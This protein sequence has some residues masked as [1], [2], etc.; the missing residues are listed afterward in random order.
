MAGQKVRVEYLGDITT[1]IVP[2]MVE[3]GIAVQEP[4]IR[5]ALADVIQETHGEDK[6]RSGG[7]LSALTSSHTFFKRKN[8]YFKANTYFKRT[9]T[10]NDTVVHQ[11]NKAGWLEYGTGERFTK[12]GE[13]RGKVTAS[14]FTERASNFIGNRALAAMQAVL[15]EEIKKL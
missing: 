6:N 12:A 10:V 15:D 9:V 7:L 11:G 2:K 14:H 13:Y 8:T 4:E 3:A 1:K 5:K